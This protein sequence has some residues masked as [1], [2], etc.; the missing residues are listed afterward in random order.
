ML[1][2]GDTR[3]HFV[4]TIL[5]RRCFVLYE[6]SLRAI[7]NV[8]RLEEEQVFRLGIV[9]VPTRV[10]NLIGSQY[11]AEHFGDLSDIDGFYQLRGCWRLDIDERLAARGLILPVRDSRMWVVALRVFRHVRDERPFLLRVRGGESLVTV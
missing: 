7:I 3:R 10:Y 8:W 2:E 11:L 1:L 5:V 6:D 9:N 4:Y